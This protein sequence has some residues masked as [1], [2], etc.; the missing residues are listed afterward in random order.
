MISICW[1]HFYFFLLDLQ[2]SQEGKY[3]YFFTS[4][5][6]TILGDFWEF[7]VLDGKV[8]LSPIHTIEH[9]PAGIARHWAKYAVQ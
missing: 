1:Y 8:V 4:L 5:P 6:P 3:I 2:L 7:R 9:S